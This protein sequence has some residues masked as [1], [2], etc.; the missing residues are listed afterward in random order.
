VRLLIEVIEAAVGPQLVPRGDSKG[1]GIHVNGDGVG[2]VGLELDGG[3]AS[4]RC[5]PHDSQ[6]LVQITVMVAG[7]LGDDERSH[8]RTY[9][10][11]TDLEVTD[12]R[13]GRTCVRAWLRH[14]V[15]TSAPKGALL[16]AGSDRDIM[17]PVTC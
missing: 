10:A 5:R 6:G 1:R 14:V 12:G 7:H 16:R 3:G 11:P 4:L 2:C 15:L 13:A 9:L 17:P 8:V